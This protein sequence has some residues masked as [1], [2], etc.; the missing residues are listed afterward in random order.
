MFPFFRLLGIDTVTPETEVQSNGGYLPIGNTGLNLG[1]AN[2]IPIK[3][4]VGIQNF[5]MSDFAAWPNP[6]TLANNGA[7]LLFPTYIIRGLDATNV[8]TSLLQQITRQLP[9]TLPNDDHGL[10]LN[11]YLTVP[12]KGAPRVG[13]DVPASRCGQSA[14]RGQLQQPDRNS[15]ESHP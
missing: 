1:G 15:I 4:D 7:A 5:P 13:A 9:N 14:Y 2:L 6:V 12:V 8:S 10:A 11:F 3:L